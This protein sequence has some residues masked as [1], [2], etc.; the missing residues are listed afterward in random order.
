MIALLLELGKA[1]TQ[2]VKSVSEA[3]KPIAEIKQKAARIAG[4]VESSLKSL[5]QSLDG[6]DRFADDCAALSRDLNALLGMSNGAPVDE[7]PPPQ[8]TLSRPAPI[9]GYQTV[10][11]VNNGGRS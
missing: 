4:K 10:N 8:S 9:G 2:E 6:A 11:S 7:P 5:D 1:M 3:I